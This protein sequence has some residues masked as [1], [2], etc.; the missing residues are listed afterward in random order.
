MEGAKGTLPNAGLVVEA[1]VRV[2]NST[3]SGVEERVIREKGLDDAIV[4]VDGGGGGGGFC[5]RRGR[6]KK[7]E[8]KKIM[9]CQ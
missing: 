9:R 3:A 5:W 7:G 6:R 1:C 8:G 2:K 4:T